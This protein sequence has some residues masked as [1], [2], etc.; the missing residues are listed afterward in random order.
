M[1][2]IVSHWSLTWLR[3]HA[4]HSGDPGPSSSGRIDSSGPRETATDAR[5]LLSLVAAGHHAPRKNAVIPNSGKP[6]NADSSSNT[7]SLTLILAVIDPH[8]PAC[9][10][11]LIGILRR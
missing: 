7:F 3:A 5:L 10:D 2:Q 9:V 11:K 4:A 1:E 8:Q 6:T